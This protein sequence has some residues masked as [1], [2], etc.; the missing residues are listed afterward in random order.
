MEI[1]NE[2]IQKLNTNFTYDEFDSYVLIERVYFEDFGFVFVEMVWIRDRN[3][4][5][6]RGGARMK[7]KN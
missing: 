1:F 5:G 4:A 2:N 3:G 6:N 7:N